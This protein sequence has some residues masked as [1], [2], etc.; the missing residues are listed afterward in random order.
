[1]AQVGDTVVN[2]VTGL[3]ITWVHVEPDRLEWDDYY[4]RKGLRVAPHVHPKMREHWHVVEGI[5]RFQ[6]GEEEHEIGAGEGVS[7]AP[8]V[9]H[10]AWNVTEGARMRVSMEPALRWAEVIE[11]LFAWA[12]DGRTDANGT[13]ESELIIGMLREYSDELAPPNM[14]TSS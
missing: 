13:P 8:G 7:A 11:Q 14:T 10:A 6:I 5:V 3:E 2:P 4:P 12:R 1:M 9:T